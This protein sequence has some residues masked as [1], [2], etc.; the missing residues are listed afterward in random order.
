[1]KKEISEET[2]KDIRKFLLL[3]IIE[4]SILFCVS[5]IAFSG[6]KIIVYWESWTIVSI[7]LIIMLGLVRINIEIGCDIARAFENDGD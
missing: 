5:W 3:V 6:Q 4:M 7:L 1:M 2:K